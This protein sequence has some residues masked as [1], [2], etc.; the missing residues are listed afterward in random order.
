MPHRPHFSADRGSEHSYTS[1]RAAS[2]TLSHPMQTLRQSRNV[3]S[4]IADSQAAGG[5]PFRHGDFGFVFLPLHPKAFY[6]SPHKQ[7]L[8]ISDTPPPRRE[9]TWLLLTGPMNSASLFWA[10][11]MNDIPLNDTP[12]GG[13]QGWRAA[14]L[15]FM[16]AV[17]SECCPVVLILHLNASPMIWASCCGVRA[18]AQHQLGSV[19][20][21]PTHPGEVSAARPSWHKKGTV[22]GV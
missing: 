2:S 22:F 4:A 1:S 13:G 7:H 19:E 3:R 6:H 20:P 16:G 8:P 10:C 15:A 14:G 21:R 18:K 9:K 5:S 11:P 12:G 17:K